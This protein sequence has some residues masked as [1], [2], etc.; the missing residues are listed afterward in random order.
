ML[1]DIIVSTPI[2]DLLVGTWNLVTQQQIFSNGR[3]RIV[4]G[5]GSRGINVYTAAGRL[6]VLFVDDNLPRI[7]ARDRTKAT[8]EEARAIIAGSIGYFGTYTVDEADKIIVYR[9][10]GTTLQ[11]M[12]DVEQSRVIVVLTADELRYR[13]PGASTGG[14]IEVVLRRAKY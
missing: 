10:E 5:P 7:A 2:K 9:V 6:S 3:K 13:N 12:L 8:A 11:N 4:F 14:Q 1:P